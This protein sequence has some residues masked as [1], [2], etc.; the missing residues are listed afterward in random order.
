MGRG[1]KPSIEVGEV[2]SSADGKYWVSVLK[3][4]SA[5]DIRVEFMHNGKIKKVNAQQLREGNFTDTDN[6]KT[7]KTSVL[8][9]DKPIDLRIS[10]ENW[11]KRKKND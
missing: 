4:N 2:Y 3:Y 7:E 10:I 5:M 1:R 8:M 11:K 6:Y 9:V